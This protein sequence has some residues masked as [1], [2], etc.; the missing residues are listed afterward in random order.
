MVLEIHEG[1]LDSTPKLTGICSFRKS[2]AIEIATG[3]HDYLLP[4]SQVK[5]SRFV[6]RVRFLWFLLSWVP[7]NTPGAQRA[8]GDYL[9]GNMKLQ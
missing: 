7:V 2:A 9:S 4:I 1:P 5:L 8:G 6:C 3:A